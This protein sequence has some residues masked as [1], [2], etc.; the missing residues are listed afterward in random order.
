M[1]ARRLI[2]NGLLCTDVSISDG[3]DVGGNRSAQRKPTCPSGRPSYPLTYNH[4]QSWGSNPGRI[5]EKRVRYPLRYP[6]TPIPVLA[7]L[8]ITFM[9]FLGTKSSNN[10]QAFLWAPIVLP[11]WQTYF[12]IHM[13]QNLFRNC[14]RIITNKLAV[15]FNHTYIDDVFNLST[16]S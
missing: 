3:L 10:Q 6:D 15:S 13:R 16:I 12:Y 9:Q 4:C 1:K 14:C 11:Y 7:F 8:Q 5:C 2:S